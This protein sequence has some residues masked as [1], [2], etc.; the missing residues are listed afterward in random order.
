MYVFF[1]PPLISYILFL[2]PLL[3]LERMYADGRINFTLFYFLG[4]RGLAVLASAMVVSPKLKE[5]DGRAN[6]SELISIGDKK[7]AKNPR[8]THVRRV[9]RTLP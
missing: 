4:S 2:R 8:T 3:L 6:T 1:S 7:Q 9:L 5:K